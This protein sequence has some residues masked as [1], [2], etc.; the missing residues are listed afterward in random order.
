MHNQGQVNEI[1]LAPGGHK[2]QFIYIKLV[3][4]VSSV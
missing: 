3:L 2:D 1:R 4:I